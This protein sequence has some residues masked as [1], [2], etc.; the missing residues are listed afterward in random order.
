[1]RLLLLAVLLWLPPQAVAQQVQLHTGTM[2]LP[3]G[4]THQAQRGTDSYPGRIAAQD[5]SLVIDYDIG[6]LAGARVNPSRRGDFLWFLEHEVNGYRAYSGVFL[7]DQD[8]R[9]ATTVI[10]DGSDPRSFPANFVASVRGEREVAAFML[11]VTS[12]RPHPKR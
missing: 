5:S 4:F 2:T 11:I 6:F 9:L 7:E 3:P 10:G 8:R 1:M 12:Y